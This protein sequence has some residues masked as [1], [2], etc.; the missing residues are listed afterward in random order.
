MLP[1][2]VTIIPRFLIFKTLGWIDTLAPL[3]VPAFFGG[4]AFNIFFCC[5]NSL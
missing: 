3:I 4:S 2:Y 1:I 5:A